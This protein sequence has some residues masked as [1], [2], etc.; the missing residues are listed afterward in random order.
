MPLGDGVTADEPLGH[1]LAALDPRWVFLAEKAVAGQEDRLRRFAAVLRSLPAWPAVTVD[2]QPNAGARPFGVALRRMSDDAQTFLEIANDSPYPIRLAGVLDAPASAPVE[3]LGR[4]LRL[5]PAPA[6]GGAA[7][8]STCSPTA[9]PAIRIGAP[10]V[11]LL[12]VTPYPSEAVLTI[13]QARFNELSAQLARLNHGLSTTSAEP[14]N[15]GFEPAANRRS[16]LAGR[17]RRQDIQFGARNGGSEHRLPR[18][19]RPAGGWRKRRP[20][21]IRSR[22]TRTIRTWATAACG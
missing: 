4:G 5:S 16:P 17:D 13:M 19:C 2:S 20:D 14:L 21:R 1:A 10:R 3:D 11:Q 15:P 8:F 12:S 7:W 6:S 22:S 18:R 9:S